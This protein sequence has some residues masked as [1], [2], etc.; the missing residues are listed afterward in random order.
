MLLQISL[1]FSILLFFPTINMIFGDTNQSSIETPIIRE[2]LTP[3]NGKIHYLITKWQISDNPA[4]F[5]QKYNLSYDDGK[6]LVYIYLENPETISKIPST[7]SIQSFYDKI[8]LA[9][10]TSEDLYQL[11]KLD[12]IQRITPPDKAQNLPISEGGISK[13]ETPIQNQYDIPLWGII[14]G[15]GVIVTFVL[16]KKK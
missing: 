2:D 7:I 8:V 14:V 13:E 10:V 12:F 4:E 1:V 11:D 9:S 6:I 16:L 5:A 15:I 3:E